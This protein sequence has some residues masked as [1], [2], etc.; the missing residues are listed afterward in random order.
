MNALGYVSNRG[1]DAIIGSFAGAAAL[2]K[3]TVSYEIANM[4]TSEMVRPVTRAV[5]PGYAMMAADATRMAVGFTKV[6][7][8]VLLFVLPAATGIALL[9]EP[10]VSVLLGPRWSDVVP[11]M[12]VLAIFGGIRAAQANTGSVYMALNRPQFAA[13]IALASIVVELGSFAIA[14][15]RFPIAQAAWFLVL[16]SLI[17]AVVNLSVLKRLLKLRAHDFLRAAGRPA[18]GSAVMAAALLP[19]MSTLWNGGHPLAAGALVLALLVTAGALVYL[20]TVLL[21]W[22]MLGQPGGTA[23][24]AIATLAQSVRRP[25]PATSSVSEH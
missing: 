13:A 21:A 23:E 25:K 11:L 9:A 16:G 1:G 20:A 10:I 5:F 17:T 2:G 7:S 19:L 6:F 8:L 22:T 24:H 4:P 15:T 3:Y 12:Q 18:L 14:L